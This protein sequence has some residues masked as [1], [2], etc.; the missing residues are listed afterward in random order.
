[1]H[2]RTHA[3]LA[4][5]RCCSPWRPS[6]PAGAAVLPDDRADALY[7]RYEG[8][9][10]TVDGPSLLVR[11]KFGEKYSVAANYYMDIVSSASIDV[12]TQ[13]SPYKEDAQPGQPRRSTC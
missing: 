13:A 5:C 10:V 8:G 6:S 3:G 12:L 11:K 2:L 4:A 7:H 1:M 9:G